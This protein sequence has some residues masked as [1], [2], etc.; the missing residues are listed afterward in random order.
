MQSNNSY[1]LLIN[2]GQTS[3]FLNVG[4]ALGIYLCLMVT[5]PNREKGISSRLNI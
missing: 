3:T 5:N 1:S 4:I 2:N